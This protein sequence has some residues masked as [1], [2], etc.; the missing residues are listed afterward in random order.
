MTL[1]NPRSIAGKLTRLNLLVTGTALVLAYVAFLGYDLYTLRQDLINSMT[2]EAGIVGANSVTALLFDDQQAAEST[3]SALDHSPHIRWAVIV[4]ADGK[5]FAEYRR[6]ESSRP[7]LRQALAAGKGREYWARGTDILLGSRIV[8]Q[9]R[10]LGAVYLLAGSGELAHRAGQFGLLSALILSLCFAIAVFATTT[11]R[12]LVTGP[13]TE[14]AGTA[15]IVSKEK[16]YSVRAPTPGSSDE[17]ALLVQSFNGML[18]QIQERDRALEESRDALE[19]RVRERT[20]ELTEANKELEAFSYS[21]AHD[22]RG[23]LQHIANIAFLLQNSAGPR[24]DDHSLIEKLVD[25][26]DRMASLIDDLLNLSRATSTPLRRTPVDLSE[27]AETILGN[28]KAEDPQRQAH[29]TIKKGGRAIV[30]EGLIQV[31]L[32]NL[33]DNA[34]KYSSRADVAEIEFGFTDEPDGTV[35]FVRDNGA[36][37]NPKYADRLFRPFQRLHSQS[38]FPGTGIGLATAH[39]IIARHGGTISAESNLNQGA[40]FYFTLPYEAEK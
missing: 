8:F 34:W 31:A 36:G 19:Q 40:V 23:P 13:L 24:V 18:E 16:D 39:R 15:Q 3:L 28:L 4:S 14:L 9:G 32:A 12:H 11:I 17:L 33:L 2:T 30:D 26:T 25:G 6:D 29:F 10:P 37:F 21:V 27:M 22:L 20:A 1:W 5:P 35:Y 7:D 38:E